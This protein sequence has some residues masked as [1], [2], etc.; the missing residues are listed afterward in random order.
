MVKRS[1]FLGTIC[2]CGLLAVAASLTGTVSAQVLE[3]IIVTATKREEALTDVPISISAIDTEKLINNGWNETTDVLDFVPNVTF[4]LNGTSTTKLNIRG[5]HS[6]GPNPSLE[7]P[8]AVFTDGIYNPRPDFVRA[9]LLDLEG[10]EVQRGPQATY[11]GHNA[12]AGSISF[13]STRQSLDEADGF[14]VVEGSAESRNKVDFAYGAPLSDTFGLRFSGALRNTQGH[15][16]NIAQDRDEPKNDTSIFRL[17]GVWVPGDQ[18]DVFFKLERYEAD[19]TGEVR[20]PITCGGA[21]NPT[22][23]APCRAFDPSASGSLVGQADVAVGVDDRI[24]EGATILPNYTTRI[25]GM[26]SNVTSTITNLADALFMSQS[27]TFSESTRAALDISHDFGAFTLTSLTGIE[28]GERSPLRD[29]DMTP[30]A[31]IFTHGYQDYDYW[32]EEL[33]L[34]SNADG[35]LAW[36]VGGL[37]QGTESGSLG[38][39]IHNLNGTWTNNR[40]DQEDNVLGLFFDINYD[41]T[42]TVNLSFGGR[43]T[44]VEKTAIDITSRA[45]L[46]P[47]GTPGS[48]SEILN[49]GTGFVANLAG[50][51]TFADGIAD[52]GDGTYSEDSFDPYVSVRFAVNDSANVYALWS[53][54]FKAGGFSNGPGTGLPFSV[55]HPALPDVYE[56]MGEESESFEIGYKALLA[57]GRVDL[58]VA[59]FSTEFTNQ[60]TVVPAFAFGPPP[61]PGVVFY[62]TGVDSEQQGVEVDG[63]LA[64]SDNLTITFAGALLD[65]EMTDQGMMNFYG[66]L[67]CAPRELIQA[68]DWSAAFGA[69]WS[70]PVGDAY[71]LTLNT[72][73]AFADGYQV[74]YEGVFEDQ[75]EGDQL[76]GWQDGWERIN[77]RAALRP[78]NGNWDVSVFGRNVTD[79]RRTNDYAPDGNATLYYVTRQ[80][81]ADWGVAFRYNF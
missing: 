34:T 77:V 35:P 55:L 59:A 81:G 26:G 37:I 4:Y 71:E 74:A 68:S 38:Q 64:A 5:V 15:I 53:S 7:A 27:G 79:N 23:P 11:Y 78:I 72:E 49:T 40:H 10:V 48:F 8:V 67:D 41:L 56:F 52:L 21:G 61:S 6:D 50:P 33:R 1:G 75:A 13:R 28:S 65:A 44:D 24:A 18:T 63:R 19:I 25:F 16:E 32:T 2:R 29:A 3:E 42:D 20:E 54:A 66:C 14:L 58:N 30:I 70:A 73:M 60:H 76:L 12:T 36:M 47:D 51:P 39:V 45:P 62:T 43:Y 17:S 46:N 80:Y 22:A 69:T 57:D 9:P 31:G